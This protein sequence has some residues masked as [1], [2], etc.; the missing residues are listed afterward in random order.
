MLT[1]VK[2]NSEDFEKAIFNGEIQ[3]DILEYL[4]KAEELYEIP[5]FSK[6]DV[7]GE[8]EIEFEYQDFISCDEIKAGKSGIAK[9]M[10][11]LILAVYERYEYYKRLPGIWESFPLEDEI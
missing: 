1:F 6:E 7:L 5:Y 11:D 9:K 4:K 2:T 8:F 10:H 3:E